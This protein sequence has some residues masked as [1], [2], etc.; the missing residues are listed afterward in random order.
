[1][2]AASADR[3]PETRTLF[4]LDCDAFSIYI[5]KYQVEELKRDGLR[6]FAIYLEV[7]KTVVKSTA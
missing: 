7:F 1:M 5:I 4:S 3:L 6:G 2:A